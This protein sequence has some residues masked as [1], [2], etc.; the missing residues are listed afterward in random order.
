[1]GNIQKPLILLPFLIIFVVACATSSNEIADNCPDLSFKPTGLTTVSEIRDNWGETRSL[2]GG[3]DNGDTL[4]FLN[5]DIMRCEEK[6]PNLTN[7][8]L[9]M[10]SVYLYEGS[11]SDRC[12]H[13]ATTWRS[14]PV[15]ASSLNIY[16][17]ACRN[18]DPNSI[19]GLSEEF[20]KPFE[21]AGSKMKITKNQLVT[22]DS[23]NNPTAYE[24]SDLRSDDYHLCKLKDANGKNFYYDLKKVAMERALRKLKNRIVK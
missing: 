7:E 10:S 8:V 14:N 9:L 21:N 15:F 24:V 22:L 3:C 13:N 16:F 5:G 6:V 1:M 12:L 11:F 19:E 17:W 23:Y 20:D 2:S 18:K 4:V